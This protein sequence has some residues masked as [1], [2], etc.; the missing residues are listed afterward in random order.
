[1]FCSEECK[2]EHKRKAKRLTKKQFN[3]K[4]LRKKIIS[5]YYRG[6]TQNQICKFV[7]KHS[8]F[9]SH[10]IYDYGC[11]KRGL[12]K[13]CKKTFTKKAWSRSS[14]C[15]ESCQKRYNKR[16][17]KY[18][19]RSRYKKLKDIGK[20]FSIKELYSLQNGI[21]HICGTKC[22]FDDKKVLDN[23]TVVCGNSYP[24]ID[25]IIPLSKGGKN[26]ID[27]ISLAH[28][29]CNSYKNAL[30]DDEYENKKQEIADRAINKMKS[31][32]RSDGKARA[33]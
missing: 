17:R 8:G 12:C 2:I 28:R 10:A 21:C 18:L 33:C 20:A 15:S 27:N 26:T 24:S 29:L 30:T 7:H 11:N 6:F 3:D 1:M 22:D 4:K 16:N 32:R 9:V 19:E 31:E 23:G 13:E 14:F 5:L 25:H